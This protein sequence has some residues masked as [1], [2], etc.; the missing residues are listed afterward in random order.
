MNLR[1]DVWVPNARKLLLDAL[2]YL[3]CILDM[4]K[5][6]DSVSANAQC[7]AQNLKEKNNILAAYHTLRFSKQDKDCFD[8]ADIE[9]RSLAVK[10]MTTK[11]L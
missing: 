3:E 11:L 2:L 1:C 6:T 9:R 5:D 10:Y 8:I 7:V 4:N